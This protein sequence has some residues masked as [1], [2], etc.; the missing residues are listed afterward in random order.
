MV[1]QLTSAGEAA[2]EQSSDPQP[3]ILC[4]KQ[5][6]IEG[7][8]VDK[9]GNHGSELRMRAERHPWRQEASVEA[10]SHPWRQGGI[11]RD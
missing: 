1:G 10:R 11:R 8:D 7:G 4:P 3:E 9:G 2:A 6:S 5:M